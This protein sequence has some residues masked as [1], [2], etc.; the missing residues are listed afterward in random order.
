MPCPPT[1]LTTSAIALTCRESYSA[2]VWCGLAHLQGG[3]HEMQC[4]QAASRHRSTARR[5]QR[6]RARNPGGGGSQGSLPRTA[7]ACCRRLGSQ[8]CSGPRRQVHQAPPLHL[9]SLDPQP[10]PAA[11]APRRCWSP[12]PATRPAPP[13]PPRWARHKGCGTTRTPASRCTLSPRH[14]PACGGGGGAGA[15][16]R[17][18]DGGLPPVGGR[19]SRHQSC[20]CSGPPP[21]L[22]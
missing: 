19:G 8:I 22:P 14:R 15:S 7:A 21:S 2:Q 12:C 6:P 10:S 17:G 16:A 5:D 4:G 11:S 1:D 9:A 18:A 3:V 13:L 20:I